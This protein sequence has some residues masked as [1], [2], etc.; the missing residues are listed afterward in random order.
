[1]SDLLGSVDKEGLVLCSCVLKGK[2]V[3]TSSFG[4]KVRNH[5]TIAKQTFSYIFLN[6][7][8]HKSKHNEAHLE[9]GDKRLS[10]FLLK[11]DTVL[12]CLSDKETSVTQVRAHIKQ[13]Q[14]KVLQA[15]VERML[16]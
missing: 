12:V 15:E 8:K 2:Q 9:I 6:V 14:S 1:M 5:E 13:I 3:V 16:A 10:G 4:K 7:S 11:A